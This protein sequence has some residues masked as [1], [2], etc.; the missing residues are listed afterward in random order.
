MADSVADA[1]QEVVNARQAASAELDEL[2]ASAREAANIPAKIKRNPVRAAGLLGGAAFLAA[3]GPRR[4]LK[5]AERRF[6]PSRADKVKSVLP[7]Q[8]ARAVSKLGDDADA[9]RAHL[10]RDFMTYLE[11][12]HPEE[13]PSGRRSFWKTYDT[14]VGIV[15]AAAAREMLKR[16]MTAPK[17]AEAE[18]AK[19][20]AEEARHEAEASRVRRSG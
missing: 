18:A 13:V 7:D 10:E 5:A 15:G 2:G 19:H 4:V 6:L 9:V 17:E 11:K 20:E 12:R 1:R 3:G 16:F 8:V 14:V